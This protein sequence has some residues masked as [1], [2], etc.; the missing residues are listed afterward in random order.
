METT[1]KFEVDM[2]PTWEGLMPVMIEL[3]KQGN[4]VAEDELMKL[5]R[6]VD[7]RNAEMKETIDERNA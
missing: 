3:V 7:Q 4:K 6:S 1:E 5:A 2:T